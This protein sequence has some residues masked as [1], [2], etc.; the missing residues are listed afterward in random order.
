MKQLIKKLAKSD[1]LTDLLMAVS[2][3]A[4]GYALMVLA[5]IIQ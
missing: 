4:I 5:A 3:L 2:I 1:T